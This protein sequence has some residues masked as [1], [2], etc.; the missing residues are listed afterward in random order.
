MKQSD[1]FERSKNELLTSRFVFVNAK[2]VLRIINKH[3]PIELV[4]KRKN[5][6]KV[7][8]CYVFLMQ[9]HTNCVYSLRDFA[10]QWGLKYVQSIQHF[11]S[12]HEQMYNESEGYR[13]LVLLCLRDM[14]RKNDRLKKVFENKI[15]NTEL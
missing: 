12:R 15:T 10:N 9:N 5:K 3:I 4:G 13:I 8:G 2:D 14:K 1:N 7:V 11:M 6:A